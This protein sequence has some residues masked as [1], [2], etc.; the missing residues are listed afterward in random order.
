MWKFALCG[1]TYGLHNNFVKG[2][3][4]SLRLKGKFWSI[5]LLLF[6]L[7]GVYLSTLQHQAH[8]WQLNYNVSLWFSQMCFCRF[9]FLCFSLRLANDVETNPVDQ[10][11][12]PRP[13]PVFT[14]RTRTYKTSLVVVVVVVTKV[15][16][17]KTYDGAKEGNSI[18]QNGGMIKRNGGIA[19][20]TE[21]SKIW[22]TWN[23]LKHGKYWIFWNADY[24][25]CTEYS[26]TRDERKVF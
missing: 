13:L 20:Y 25:E 11:S 21:Y 18:R 26:K 7:E 10:R 24:T 3:E 9:Y 19:E 23:I 8:L 17:R 15:F 12:G 2:K 1:R 4:F 16:W 6:Y 5:L 22:N 14:V